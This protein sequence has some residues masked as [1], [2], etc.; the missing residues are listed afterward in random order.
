MSKILIIGYGNPNREDDGVAWHIL[1]KLA[2]HFNVPLV[3]ALAPD[4]FDPDRY[5]HLVFELQLMP[6]MSEGIAGYD[7]V[8]FVDAHTGAYPEEVRVAALNPT[9]Q[10]SPFTHH[11]TPE[12]CLTLAEALYGRAPESLMVSVRGYSFGYKTELSSPTA[13]LA[14]KA[15]TR[16]INWVEEKSAFST[17]T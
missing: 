12:S 2:A 13:T 16:I 6:E 7:Y 3:P 9:F 8:C 15:V 5:P 17:S 11:L 4:E 1:Q 10:T 14:N